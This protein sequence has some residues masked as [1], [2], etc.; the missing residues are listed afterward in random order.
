MVIVPG[1]EWNVVSLSKYSATYGDEITVTATPASGYEL[2]KI[3]VNS[4]EISGNKFTM[5]AKDT[6]VV[7]TFKE[8]VH[9]LTKVPAKAATC[10]EEG[11]IIYYICNDTDCGCKKLY[12]DP[13]GQNEISLADTVVPASGHSLDKVAAKAA[14]CTEDGHLAHWKCTKCG[15]LFKD[16]DGNI[17]ISADNVLVEATGHDTE[18][19]KH[20]SEKAPTYKDDG[21]KE[22]YECP[23]CGKKFADPDCKNP[24]TE[25]DLLIP[26]KGSAVQGEEATVDD[27]I[28]R[29]TYQATDGTGT[30]TDET[31]SLTVWCGTSLPLLAENVYRQ[32]G[33]CI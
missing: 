13:A 5:P 28:Y 19:V 6:T 12:S 15:K 14:T 7:V 18:H 29:V 23:E 11:N 26:K 33:I 1:I 17:E 2:D 16:A 27:L 3:T 30:V 21:H 32:S 25:A 31:E 22:Y 10:T 4:T 9:T 24:V 8:K 20:V